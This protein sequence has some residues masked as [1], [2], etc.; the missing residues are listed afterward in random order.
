M[1]ASERHD[2][3]DH[4]AP[5]LGFIVLDAIDIVHHSKIPCIWFFCPFSIGLQVILLGF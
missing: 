2:V 5:G 4:G 1:Q 3:K